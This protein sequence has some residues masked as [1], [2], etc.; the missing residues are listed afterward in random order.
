MQERSP[1]RWTIQILS[2]TPEL[3]RQR[4][5]PKM[6][7]EDSLNDYVKHELCENAGDW[8]LYAQDREE[9]ERM[10]DSFF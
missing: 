1:K 6:R 5:R 8:S 2:W 4:G 10:T 3:G 7:W 9:W